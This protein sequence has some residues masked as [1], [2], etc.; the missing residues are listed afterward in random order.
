MGVW[1]LPRVADV[2]M[3]TGLVLS[4]LGIFTFCLKRGLGLWVQANLNGLKP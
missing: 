4:F 3:K 2:H 1:A